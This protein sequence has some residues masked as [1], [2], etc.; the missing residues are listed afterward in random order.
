MFCDLHI[1]SCYA[2][3][4]Q[5]PEEIIEEAVSKKIGL[6]SITDDDTMDSYRDLPETAA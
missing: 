6:I 4:N 5:T 3:G 2:T 1:H